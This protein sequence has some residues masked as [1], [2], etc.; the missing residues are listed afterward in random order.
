M[1][2]SSIAAPDLPVE[3]DD[4]LELVLEPEDESEV[5][6]LDA[7]LVLTTPEVLTLVLTVVGLPETKVPLPTVPLLEEP[8][9]PVPIAAGAI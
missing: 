2:G 8:D 4:G 1:K 6:V 5:S 9:E 7:V 3:D